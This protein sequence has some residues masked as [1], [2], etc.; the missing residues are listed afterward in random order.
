MRELYLI[1]RQEISGAFRC[2]LGT[3]SVVD[4]VE[5]AVSNEVE[6]IGAFG[7]RVDV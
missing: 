6:N 3:T 7:L 4:E 5:D 2:L 1:V